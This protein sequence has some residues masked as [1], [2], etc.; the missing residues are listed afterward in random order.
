MLYKTSTPKTYID[1]MM[2]VIRISIIP[3][4]KYIREND[5]VKQL[6]HLKSEIKEVEDAYSNFLANKS[7][8]AIRAF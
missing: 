8:K 2:L 7:K 3:A 4:R 1:E 6:D 5:F